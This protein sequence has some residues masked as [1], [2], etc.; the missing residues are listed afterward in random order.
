M[1]TPEL[2]T[3]IDDLRTWL[4]IQGFQEEERF[5]D[6]RSFGDWLIVLARPPCRVRIVRDRSQWSIDISG[7]HIPRWYDTDLWQACLAGGEAVPRV[8][9]LEDQIAFVR[10]SLD[11]IEAAL[12]SPQ[13]LERCLSLQRDARALRREER[14]RGH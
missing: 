7:E 1:P 13:E 14:R 6:S 11:G 9:P 10:T 4:I 3:T 5:Y 12:R 2:P 8:I